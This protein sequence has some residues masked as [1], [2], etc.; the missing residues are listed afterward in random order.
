MA[1]VV[2]AP[3]Y[4]CQQWGLTLLEPVYP[5]SYHWVCPVLG[6]QGEAWV[7]KLRPP[8]RDCQLEIQTLRDYG[9]RGAARLIASD[10]ERGALL[11][12]RLD[13]GSLLAAVLL[14]GD[15]CGAESEALNLAALTM[16]QLWQ[17]QPSDQPNLQAW[18]QGFARI[19]PGSPLAPERWSEAQELY[20][21]WS[22]EPCKQVLLHADLHPDNLLLG[23][24]GDYL[25]IDPHGRVGDPAF[26]PAAYLRNYLTH[27]PDPVSLLHQRIQGFA[28]A[29]ALSPTR[30][31]GWGYAQTVLSALWLWE[32][33]ADDAGF[34]VVAAMERELQIA[35]WLRE[36]WQ[37]LQ[38][39]PP[40]RPA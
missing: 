22:A 30:I 16:L 14:R 35:G 13:P 28:K 31:A 20:L 27:Q 26:E 19:G 6:P 38:N 32:D 2:A 37:E 1:G 24:K 4:F 5:R 39:N 29:L 25:A 11:L 23:P 15:A 7:L 12:E 40:T 10:P 18:A 3:G 34:D 17:N 21:R 36:I 33:H 8:D 9:G